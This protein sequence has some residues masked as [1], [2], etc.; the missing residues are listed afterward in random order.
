MTRPMRSLALAVLLGLAACSNST[1]PAVTA[2]DVTVELRWFRAPGTCDG[3]PTNP[4]E[5][6]YHLALESIVARHDSYETPGF[7]SAAGAVSLTANASLQLIGTF[8]EIPAIPLDRTGDHDTTLQLL[9]VEHDGASHDPDM[10][11]AGAFTF[12]PLDTSP[13]P[14]PGT[15]TIDAAPGCSVELDYTVL[16]TP[17]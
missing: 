14:V 3:D 10:D 4:G 5:F 6:A 13:T 16:W 15:L 1:D 9:V 7:P 2:Y 12:L 8:I 11:L 17:A